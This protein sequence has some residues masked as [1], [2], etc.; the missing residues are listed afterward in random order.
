M[1]FK[2]FFFRDSMEFLGHV[3][4]VDGVQVDPR[5][6]TVIRVWRPLKDV[7]AVQQ[8]LGL[9][10]YFKR[11]MLGYAK[12]VAPLRKLTEKSVPFVFEGAAVKA[13]ANLKYSLSHALVLALPNPDLPF[14]VVVDASAFGCGAVLLQIQGRRLSTATNSA[15]QRGTTAVASRSCGL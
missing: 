8:L 4:S 11:Y 1:T 13:F 6:V 3:V 10:N 2:C 7:H 14:K 5:K 15:L 9:G 12:L